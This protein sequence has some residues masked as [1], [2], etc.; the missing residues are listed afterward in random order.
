M[1]VTTRIATLENSV[2]LTLE[3]IHFT[4]GCEEKDKKQRGPTCELAID[5]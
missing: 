4:P 1:S 2:D 3:F 5:R